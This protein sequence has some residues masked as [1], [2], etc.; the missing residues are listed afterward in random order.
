MDLIAF[1]PKLAAGIQYTLL[2]TSGAFLLG[3]ILA[4]PLT[5]ARRSPIR[6]IRFLGSAYVE[7]F[8]G[9]PPLPWLF[10]VFFA[11]PTVGIR[12]PA[13]QTG[14]L[15]FGLISAAY[16]TE[17]YRAGFRAVPAGQSEAGEA[18]GLSRFHIYSKILVPQAVRTILPMAIAFL[19]GLLKDSAL[20]SVIGVQDITALALV[21]N[22]QSGE[23]LAVFISTAALYLLLSIPVGVFGRWLGNRLG[24][25]RP[26]KSE[27]LV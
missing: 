15:V 1:W 18:L 2:I 12:L 19:I 21:Q 16:L 5:A 11:L 20:V 4:V 13:V 24:A 9:V 27:V 8:R 22:R 25:V 10:L 3:A 7:V 23:G 6:L 14:I 17:I 26:R